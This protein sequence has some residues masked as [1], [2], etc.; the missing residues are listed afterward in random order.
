MSHNLLENLNN[1]LLIFNYLKKTIKKKLPIHSKLYIFLLFIKSFKLEFLKIL[2]KLIRIS[3]FNKKEKIILKIN[4]NKINFVANSFYTTSYFLYDEIPE[5]PILDFL[6]NYFH[7]K[8]KSTFLDVGGYVGLHS[9]V[10][11]VANQNSKIH[12]FEADKNKCHILR[13]NITI[14][15]FNNINLNEQ[16]ITSDRKSTV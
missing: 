11:K 7:N 9:F 5:K 6:Y 1:K 14:N 4:K 12:I 10:V 2:L 8:K 15:K 3:L 16:F 13:K